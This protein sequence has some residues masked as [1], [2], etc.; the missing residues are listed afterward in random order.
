M[1]LLDHKRATIRKKAVMALHHCF[2]LS[3][4]SVASYQDKLRKA[5][6]DKDPS[7]MGASLCLFHD[8]ILENPMPFK[9]LVPSFVV[10]LK[11]V[12]DHRLP[13][14]YSYH[15]MPAPWIQIKLLQILALLGAADKKASEGMYEVVREVMKRAGYIIV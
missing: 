2:K 12:T 9:D 6:C 1:L 7:V 15:R 5:L 3:S 4:S 13:P 14:D 10:I 8:L 11:Q